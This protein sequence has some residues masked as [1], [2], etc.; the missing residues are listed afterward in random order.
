MSEQPH[1]RYRLTLELQADTFEELLVN[2][3]EIQLDLRDGNT[4][5]HG[6]RFHSVMYGPSSGYVV[7]VHVDTEMTHERYYEQLEA[8]LAA[9]KEGGGGE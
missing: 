8:Y 3:E 4:K 7:D 2:M 6:G 5:R 1:R 9:K